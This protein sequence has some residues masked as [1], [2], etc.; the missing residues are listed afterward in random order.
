MAKGTIFCQ[1]MT[2][3]A[4]F[5]ETANYTLGLVDC[6]DYL[7]IKDQQSMEHR[8]SKLARLDTET[9]LE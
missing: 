6:W 8:H 7:Q 1:I 9:Q 2:V 4:S 3:F 5:E